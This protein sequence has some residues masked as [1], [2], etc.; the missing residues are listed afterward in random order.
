MYFF[1][2]S[3]NASIELTKH[4]SINT[5]QHNHDAGYVSLRL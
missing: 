5:K 4:S 2:N 1:V 3:T